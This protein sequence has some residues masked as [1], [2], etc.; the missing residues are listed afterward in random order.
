V[1]RQLHRVAVP[2]IISR[3]ETDYTFVKRLA[4]W[5][6]S[7]FTIRLYDKPELQTDVRLRRSLGLCKWAC[8]GR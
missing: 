6:C 7:Q 4:C 5:L 1:S 2:K 8:V 3:E